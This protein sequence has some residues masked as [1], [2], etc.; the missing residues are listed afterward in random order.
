[1]ELAT[2]NLTRVTMWRIAMDE[3]EFIKTLKE[4]G[5]YAASE[6]LPAVAIALTQALQLIADLQERL[7]AV[8]LMSDD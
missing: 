6:Q 7:T 8:E 2:P 5:A 3:I 1:M 4:A